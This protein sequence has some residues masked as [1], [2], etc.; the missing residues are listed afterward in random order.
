[1]SDIQPA[2]KTKE[3]AQ[4]FAENWVAL[5]L[6]GV[7]GNDELEVALRS[8]RAQIRHQIRSEVAFARLRKVTLPRFRLSLWNR[9]KLWAIRK[10]Q[11][12]PK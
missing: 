8:A 11:G 12:R 3:A 9:L 2:T 10:L 5:E 1:M 4:S 6:M 7:V